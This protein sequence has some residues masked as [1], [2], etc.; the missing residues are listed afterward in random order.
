MWKENA[1]DSNSK[2]LSYDRLNARV[3]FY[4]NH[5][6]ELEKK[7]ILAEEKIERMQGELKIALVELAKVREQLIEKEQESSSPF[8]ES[9]NYLNERISEK[10]LVGHAQSEIS[11][12]SFELSNYSDSVDAVNNA[13]NSIAYF[14]YAIHFLENNLGIIKGSFYIKN[15][16]AKPL[17][18]PYVCFRFSPSHLANLEEIFLLQQPDRKNSQWRFVEREWAITARDKGEVWICPVYDMKIMPGSTIVINDFSFFFKDKHYSCIVEAFVF[19][20][21]RKY[22]IKAANRIVVNFKKSCIKA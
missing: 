12:S 10:T 4:K 20:I 21:N 6:K 13:Y 19:Y 5:S 7:L 17:E 14:D 16:G 15:T 8:L 1:M 18:H 3:H 9:G 22:K 11:K 2:H